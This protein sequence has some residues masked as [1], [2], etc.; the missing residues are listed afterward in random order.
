[1]REIEA[2]EHTG[3]KHLVQDHSWFGGGAA[4]AAELLMSEKTHV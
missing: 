2:T 4:I 3:E 1:M